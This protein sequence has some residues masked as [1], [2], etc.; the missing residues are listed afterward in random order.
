MPAE[1]RQIQVTGSVIVFDAFEVLAGSNQHGRAQEFGSLVK[2]K[3]EQS[4]QGRHVR[5]K[6]R[7][8]NLGIFRGSKVLK[9]KVDALAGEGFWLNEVKAP[10]AGYIKGPSGGQAKAKNQFIG[11]QFPQVGLLLY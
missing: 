6:G 11:P 3:V 2:T 5:N 4:I 9:P 7:A 1:T 8:V 10:G